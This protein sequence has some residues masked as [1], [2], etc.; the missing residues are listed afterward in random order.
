M[1]GSRTSRI[2]PALLWVI[3]PSLALVLLVGL[4]TG[5]LPRQLQ[6]TGREWGGLPPAA[7]ATLPP[8]AFTPAEPVEPAATPEPVLPAA[9]SPTP[10]DAERLAERLADAGSTGGDVATVVIDPATGD[11]VQAENAERPMIPA[12]TLKLPVSA[13]ALQAFGADH[14]F[15]TTVVMPTAPEEPEVPQI[16]LV[17]GGDPY[18]LDQGLGADGE[19]PEEAVGIDELAELTAGALAADGVTEVALGFDAGLFGGPDWNEDWPEN[20]RSQVTPISALWLDGGFG[21][22]RTRPSEPAREAAEVFAEA[23][24]DHDIEVTETGPAD[25]PATARTLAEVSSMPLRLIV[26]RVISHS[27]NNAA[28]VLLR[29]LGT[30][31][32][33]DG[34]FEAGT[35]R[36]LQV[37]DELGLDTDGAELRD[38]SGLSRENRLSTAAVVESVELGVVD[39]NYRSLLTGMSVAGAEGTLRQRFVEPGTGPGRGEVRAKTGTLRQVHALAGYV[40]DDDGGLLVFA[41]VINGDAPENDYENR[42]WLERMAA[43]LAGCGCR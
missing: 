23:L 10:V 7:A 18:L 33:G 20:Y 32:S 27:D 25:A 28:E 15:S 26:E 11:Q 13:A 22:D 19:R 35:A 40:I 34:S 31:D 41:F 36:L 16:V 29:Q 14:R 5:I 43:E 6:Q 8:G 9:D 42:T 2:G 1:S 17:G 39:D 3:G 24:A 37:L 30:L 21:A 38:G 4:G 12:S